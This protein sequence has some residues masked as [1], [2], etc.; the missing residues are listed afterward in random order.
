MLN[1]FTAGNLSVISLL[2]SEKEGVPV[3]KITKN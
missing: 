3:Q 1:P 2:K